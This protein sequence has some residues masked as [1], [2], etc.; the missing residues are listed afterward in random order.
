MGPSVFVDTMQG[1]GSNHLGSHETPIIL[2]AR[3]R[4]P[5]TSMKRVQRLPKSS[6]WVSG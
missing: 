3:T 4:P 5:E 1:Q 2:S 6:G